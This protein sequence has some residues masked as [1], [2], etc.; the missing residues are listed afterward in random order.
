MAKEKR[1]ATIAW[2]ERS[3]PLRGLSIA[4]ANGIFDAA[5]NG[6]TQRL[7]WMYQEIE[8]Q[9]PVLS[10]AVTRRS[11]AAANFIWRVSERAAMDGTLSAEQKDAAER[12]LGDI[13]NLTDLFE[14]LD[15][16]LFRGFAHAQP[17]WEGHGGPSRTIQGGP[18]RTT[19]KVRHIELIDSW[20]FLKKD[21]EWLFNPACDGFSSNCVSCKN[22]RLVTVE[23]RRPVDV[24]ALAI[25]LRQAVGTRDWGR[26]IE[27]YAL[28]KPAVVMSPN[29]T[30]KDR[31]GYL[32]AASAL[33]NGQVTVWPSGAS[34]M[35]FAGSS[36]GVDPFTNFIQHQEKTILMLATGG[37]LGSMA[38]SGAGTLAGN[39]QKD[40]WEQIVARDAGVIAQAVMR[41][42]VRPFIEEAFPGRPCA[43]DFDFD[44]TQKPTPK[45][46]FETAAAARNAGY[47]IAKEDL[48]EATGYTL[49]EVESGGVGS[50]ELGVPGS[51]FVGAFPPRNPQ[52]GTRNAQLPNGMPFKTRENVFKNASSVLNAEGHPP[53]PPPSQ[54]AK[55]R[56]SARSA[57]EALSKDSSEVAQEIS[58]LMAD[59]SPEAAR[60]L[61]DK[62]PSLLPED[63]ALAAV[64]AEAMAEAYGAAGGPRS[65]AAVANSTE[66]RAKDPAHCPTHGTPREPETKSQHD[67][68]GLTAMER[69]VSEPGHNVSRGKSAI[70]EV[71][72]HKSGYVDKAM[73]RPETGWIRFDWGDPGDPHKDE[74]GVTYRHGHGL[75]HIAAKHP[76]ALERLPEI[77]AKGDIYKHE[78][79]GKLYVL[80]GTSYVVLGSLHG[81][82][83]KII[84]DFISS[85][86]QKKLDFIKKQP[87]AAKPGE[88]KGG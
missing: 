77:I 7:H 9:N 82:A 34:L 68:Y 6:D 40:V 44:L 75:S 32:D 19:P 39:A 74:R 50:Y 4:A 20:K 26:F 85:H 8:C 55:N 5:R 16:A 61:L 28:P 30:E 15:L 12:F 78:E 54:I 49:E 14:H 58:E 41:S 57:L 42:L 27:R 66:C 36:R 10:M 53:S 13:D 37:T 65:V 64:I 59:P 51:G 29:A 52:L 22:A 83:K 84:T 88:N 69:L 70:N 47:R 17:I 46:I 80:Y 38:E 87:R 2:L 24:P 60:A 63:P 72:R 79:P 48:E 73:F 23:R 18:S 31:D 56:P 62:L 3:N 76:E 33:E 25:H 35:D 81:G 71:M 43:V 11:G 1:N 67:R 21:G 45:E 86:D